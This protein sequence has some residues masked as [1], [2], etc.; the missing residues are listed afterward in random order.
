[1]DDH[2][3]GG[4]QISRQSADDVPNSRYTACGT[5]DNDN[6]MLYQMAHRV[7][8]LAYPLKLERTDIPVL[9]VGTL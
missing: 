8:R 9:G 5:A 7:F 2:Q 3:E 6:V 4:W 1:V